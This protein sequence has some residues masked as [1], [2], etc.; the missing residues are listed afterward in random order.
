MNASNEEVNPSFDV[1]IAGA[2]PAG[3]ATAIILQQQKLRV[4][5]IDITSPNKPKVGESLLPAVH[6]LLKRLGITSIPQLMAEADYKPCLGN[7]SAWGSDRWTHRANFSN[8]EGNGWHVN[9]PKFDEALR[10]KAKAIGVTFIESRVV[11]VRQKKSHYFIQLSPNHFFNTQSLTA[12]WIVDATGRASK[13]SRLLQLKKQVFSQQMAAIGW[14]EN[15]DLNDFTTKIKSV[16]NG[17]W[18]TA[19]LPHKKRVIVFH[20]L[21]NQVTHFVHQP[22][23]FITAFNKTAVLPYPIDMGQLTTTLKAEKANV[24][25]L[26]LKFPKNFFAVGDAV[27]SFDPLASQGVFFALYSGI[28]AAE[29]ILNSLQTPEKKEDLTTHYY[30]QIDAIFQHNQK[31]RKYFYHSETRFKSMAYWEMQQFGQLLTNKEG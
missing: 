6:R 24:E 17:W 12:K 13:I 16:K 29:A 20:G 14:F 28:K 27:F 8:P 5:L 11:N 10:Q 25:K 31:T 15:L 9:R 22:A 30:Q 19:A 21:L 1:L 3:C 4:G 23:S 26:P 2:G 7:T 18:Y